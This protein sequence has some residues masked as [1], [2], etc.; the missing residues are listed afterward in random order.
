LTKHGPTKPETTQPRNRDTG[1]GLGNKVK[2]RVRVIVQI[3]G[4]VIELG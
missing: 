2:N 4:L 1:L 3:Y